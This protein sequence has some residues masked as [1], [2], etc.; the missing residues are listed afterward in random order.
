MANEA[1]YLVDAI[2]NFITILL[3]GKVI[4]SWV[5]QSPGDPL[6]PLAYLVETLTEPLCAPVRR[7]IPPIGMIDFSLIFVFIGLNIM[8]NAIRSLIVGGSF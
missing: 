5:P 1:L 2:F 7:I 8:Q 3:I 6:A 4:F